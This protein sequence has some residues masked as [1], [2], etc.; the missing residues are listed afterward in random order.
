MGTFIRFA[1]FVLIFVAA[2]VLVQRIRAVRNR[3]LDDEILRLAR[4][5]GALELVDVCRAFAIRPTLATALL[6]G[7]VAQ[8]KLRAETTTQGGTRWRLA[9][10]STLPEPPSDIVH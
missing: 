4:A 2:Y 8:G 3:N 9:E 10:P 7:L 1:L 5:Q 6:D